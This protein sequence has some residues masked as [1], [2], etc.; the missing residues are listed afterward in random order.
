MRLTVRS[1][2]LLLSLA[3]LG[4]CALSD[5]PLERVDL[6]EDPAAGLRMPA[7]DELAHVGDERRTTIDGPQRPFEGRIFGTMATAEE[8]FAFYDRELTSVGWQRRLA[9]GLSTVELDLRSWCKPKVWFRLAIKDKER[10]FQPGFYRGRDYTTVY[11][12]TLI[13]TD[14]TSPCP[15][16]TPSPSAR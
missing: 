10:A 12:A 4:G 3:V 7:A 1:T 2:H 9:L 13:G 5:V 16:R 11:E 8:V 15:G 14:P 6:V